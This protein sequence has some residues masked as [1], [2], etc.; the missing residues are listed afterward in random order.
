MSQKTNVDSPIYFSH[1]RIE[2]RTRSSDFLSGRGK[3]QNNEIDRT[4]SPFY[5]IFTFHIICIQPCR[6]ENVMQYSCVNDTSEDMTAIKKRFH[7]G[8]KNCT[9]EKIGKKERRK[10]KFN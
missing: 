3:S 6:I 10:S 8:Q 1:S 4:D 2:K 9:R 5:D 7:R